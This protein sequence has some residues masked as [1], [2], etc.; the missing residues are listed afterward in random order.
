MIG[1]PVVY[2]VIR[3]F[4]LIVFIA[5]GW[6]I[7]YRYENKRGYW[8]NV[9]PLIVIYSL[10]EGLRWNRGWD[11][12][13]YYQDLTGWLYTDYSEFIYLGWITLFKQTALP[14]WSAFILYSTLLITSF[15]CLIKLFPKVAIWALPLFFLITVDQS[16]NLIRQYLALSFLMFSLYYLLQ[17]KYIYVLIF[18]FVCVNI[19][20]S[21]FVPI[22]IGL[23]CYY[24]AKSY[25]PQTPVLIVL[26]YLTFYFI[27][28]SSYFTYFSD[29][30]SMV[31]PKTDTRADAYIDTA[32]VWLT[33]KG[34]LSYKHGG[35]MGID[36]SV[37]KII[38]KFLL[39][40]FII[41]EGFYATEKKKKLRFVFWI[42]YFA[43]LLDVIRG[44]IENYIRI[45]HWIAFVIPIIVGMIYS[46]VRI[47]TYI[48]FP[49]WALIAAYYGYM[50]MYS[51]MFI[52]IPIGYAFIWDK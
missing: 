36:Q 16:E 6:W 30:V 29:F 23:V 21:G 50:C 19:H 34:S 38:V 43:L 35:K 46:R 41:I 28:D 11:Y 3:T 27:W 22:L 31:M 37:V 45:Y 15:L 52:V 42:A 47:H 25:N 2:W 26:I 24:I 44:D 5:T 33:A 18:L 40:L 51:K 8:K 7:S 20:F 32:D 13:H 1:N 39:Y 12:E 9:L 14:F 49:S 10:A 4:V 17:Q 48:L